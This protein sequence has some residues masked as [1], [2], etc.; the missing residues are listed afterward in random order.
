[1]YDD[2]QSQRRA[3]DSRSSRFGPVW[4]P[5]PQY[6]CPMICST[7]SVL[8]SI[9]APAKQTTMSSSLFNLASVFLTW[10]CYL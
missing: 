9:L 3:S 8:C 7:L 1:M 4:G 5:N 6:P 2:M 10:V